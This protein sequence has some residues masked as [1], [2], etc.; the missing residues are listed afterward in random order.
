MTKSDLKFVRSLIERANPLKMLNE[1]G[2]SCVFFSKRFAYLEA[3]KRI[4]ANA[5][6]TYLDVEYIL[7][8]F[9]KRK[10]TWT[11][12]MYMC[13]CKPL[14]IPEHIMLDPNFSRNKA[15]LRDLIRALHSICGTSFDTG[16]FD[17][18]FALFM[19]E[20]EVKPVIKSSEELENEK[21]QKTKQG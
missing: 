16:D 18:A 5:A 1:D 10:A 6:I 20:N 15:V 21:R 8:C 9:Y 12:S 7:Y 13:Y 19:A 4:Y 11:R 14:G 3:L 2:S 17:N